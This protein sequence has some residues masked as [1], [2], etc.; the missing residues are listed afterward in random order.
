MSMLEGVV[1]PN[2]DRD[3]AWV[4]VA[5]SWAGNW[6]GQAGQCGTLTL[7]RVGSEVLVAFLGGDP[8]KPIIVGQLYNQR[9]QPPAFNNMDDLPSSRFVSGIKSREVKS[10]R[11]NQLRFD[12]TEGEISAQLASEH[13]AS[14][15]NLGFITGPRENGNGKFRGDGAELRTEGHIALRASKGALLSAWPKQGGS[16]LARDEMA[17]LLSDCSDL[18]KAIGELAEKC[19]ALSIERTAIDQ[20]M[21]SVKNWEDD[22]NAAGIGVTSPAGISL[23]TPEVIVSYAGKDIEN[24][25]QSDFSAT[26]GRRAC[27][28][29]G[30]GLSLFAQSEGITAIAQNGKVLVQSQAE[31]T[32]VNAATE[33]MLT[34][35]EGKVIAMGKEVVLVADDGSFIKIGGGIT[36]G[37]NATISHYGASFP[38]KGPKT[39]SAQL[40]KFEGGKTA[41]KFKGQYYAD[42]GEDSVAASGATMEIESTD[43]TRRSETS[44]AIGHSTDLESDIMHNA[45][46]RVMNG[47]PKQGE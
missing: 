41:L 12:D 16:I 8:D 15:L 17:R 5:S 4:R 32:E 19:R 45:L 1:Q 13:A 21:Q 34:A 25:A 46:A 6:A 33:L 40:P 23:S 29:A 42:R 28:N 22:G 35:S 37:T 3:S 7:P 39:M 44:D 36:L 26:A 9:G 10:G 47:E 2:T 11:S 31:S 38:F 43:G 18:G 14:Q 27:L 30:K 24:A 20:L